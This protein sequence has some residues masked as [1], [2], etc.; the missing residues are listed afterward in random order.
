MKTL[1]KKTSGRWCVVERELTCGSPIEA[2]VPGKGWLKGR[3]E[4]HDSLGGYFFL[5][6]SE[7]VRLC[8]S[9]NLEVRD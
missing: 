9:E 8:L 3:I 2:Y 6:E 7:N 4:H 1:V 5:C